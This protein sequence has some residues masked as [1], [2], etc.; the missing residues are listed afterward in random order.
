MWFIKILNINLNEINNYTNIFEI[1]ISQQLEV[2]KT[3]SETED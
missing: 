1:E 3:L 2:Q